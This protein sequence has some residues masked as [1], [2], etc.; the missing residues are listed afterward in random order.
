MEKLV[1]KMKKLSPYLIVLETT[2]GYESTVVASLQSIDFPLAVIN[3]RQIQ[4]FAQA[5]LLKIA[6]IITN[7]KS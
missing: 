4:G 6:I 5:S 7:R 2:G 3:T 1:K